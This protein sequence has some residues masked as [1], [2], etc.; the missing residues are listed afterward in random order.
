IDVHMSDFLAGPDDLDGFKGLEACGGFSYGDVL[1]AGEGWAKSILINAR[2]RDG[3]QAFFARKDIFALG[4]CNGCQKMSN[5]H[6]L[7]PGT[8]FWPHFVRNRSE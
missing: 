7:I 8:E 6:E 4:V 1:G 3:F 5:L 2:A